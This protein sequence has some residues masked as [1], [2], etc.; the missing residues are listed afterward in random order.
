[1][2]ELADDKMKRAKKR[3]DQLKG[4]YIHLTVYIVVNTFILIN[5]MLHTENF[6]QWGHF[7]TLFFWGIGILFHAAN[8][9]NYNP[10]FPKSWEERQ[11]QKYMDKDREEAKKFRR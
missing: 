11:I 2:E 9:F 7:V 5:I 3:V 1:M 10:L 6:W 4:F 8:T